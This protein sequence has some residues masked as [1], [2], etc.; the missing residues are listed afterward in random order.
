MIFSKCSN[1]NDDT[2]LTRLNALRGKQERSFCCR[3]LLFAIFKCRTTICF[4]SGLQTKP[5]HGLMRPHTQLYKQKEKTQFEKRMKNITTFQRIE[6]KRVIKYHESILLGRSGSAIV[7][8]FL[9]TFSS[10]DQKQM[11][12]KKLGQRKK[13]NNMK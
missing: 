8:S 9:Q 1:R 12:E 10:I 2:L 7:S 6:R 4:Y 3:I 11:A 5:R 13:R